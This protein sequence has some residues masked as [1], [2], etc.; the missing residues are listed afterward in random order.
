MED[1]T[2][3]KIVNYVTFEGVQSQ[4]RIKKKFPGRIIHYLFETTLVFM[5]HSELLGKLIFYFSRIV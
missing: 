3:P 5:K 4:V 1:L 2:V